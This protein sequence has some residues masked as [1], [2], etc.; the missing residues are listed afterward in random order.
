[1]QRTLLWFVA[2]A[3]LVASSPIFNAGQQPAPENCKKLP[4]DA[5]WPKE[6]VWKAALRGIEARGPQ[7]KVT[8]PD[9]KYEANTV[10]KVQNAVKFTS[11]HN[12]RL[13][14]LNSGHDFSTASNPI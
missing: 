14:I 3:Q 1:M 11:E 12:L 9:Y 8:R 4:I 6:E 2:V 10:T 7:M 13:S 5:D